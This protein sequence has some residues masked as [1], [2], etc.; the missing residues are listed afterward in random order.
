[1]ILLLCLYRLPI[2]RNPGKEHHLARDV[3]RGLPICQK[4]SVM[5]ERGVR[6]TIDITPSCFNG[7]EERVHVLQ[8]PT[9]SFGKEGI[10]GLEHLL[11]FGGSIGSK[12]EVITPECR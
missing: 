10:Y 7:A 2:L 11:A 4:I 8:L 1:M 5:A 6:P 12:S 3:Q 9:L